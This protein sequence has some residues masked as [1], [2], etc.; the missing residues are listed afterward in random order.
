MI[1]GLLTDARETSYLIRSS[2][3]K[4]NALPLSYRGTGKL[5]PYFTT[6]CTSVPLSLLRVGV[7]MGPTSTQQRLHFCHFGRVMLAQHLRVMVDHLVRRMSAPVS[8]DLAAHPGINEV[9]NPAS[10]KSVHPMPGWTTF[11]FFKMG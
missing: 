4:P 10:P 1:P 5:D 9:R 8:N 7:Q 2:L 6:R 11:S 3:L